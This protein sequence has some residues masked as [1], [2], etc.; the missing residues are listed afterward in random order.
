VQR[1]QEG[2]DV[3][4]VSGFDRDGAADDVRVPEQTLALKPRALTYVPPSCSSRSRP[5]SARR[6]TRSCSAPT[7]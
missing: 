3:Y 1:V 4:A 7:S 2:D 5:A 6:P